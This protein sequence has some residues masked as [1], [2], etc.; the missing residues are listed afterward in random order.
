[1]HRIW[2]YVMAFIGGIVAACSNDVTGAHDENNSSSDTDIVII[3]LSS[4]SKSSSSTF[5]HSNKTDLIR[6]CF[7]CNKSTFP[8]QEEHVSGLHFPCIFQ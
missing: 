2:I 8:T 6:T 5:F 4:S 1:M 7:L 3:E